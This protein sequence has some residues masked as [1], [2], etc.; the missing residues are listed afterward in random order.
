MKFS[1]T[2]INILKNFSSINQ[3]ILFKPGNIL[4]TKNTPNNVIAKAVLE[5]EMPQQF[6][7]YDLH[8]FLG[9]VSLFKEIDDVQVLNDHLM[10]KQGK[11]SIEY[12]FA[13]PGMIDAPQEKHIS[14]FSTVGGDDRPI[15]VSFNLPADVTTQLI[16]ALG[17]LQLTDVAV[18][19]DGNTVTVNVLDVKG[20]KQDVFSAE[21]GETDLEFVVIFK[22]ENLKLMN[23]EKNPISYNVGLYKNMKGGAIAGMF[24]TESG[25]LSY[26]IAADKTGSRL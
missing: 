18:I 9:A 21:V 10:L 6:A 7:I 24:T 17:V 5:D 1:K 19:G 13:D 20:K 15:A 25:N 8:Q 14:L 23:S 22:E 16:K 3:S 12:R 2:T 26:V 11:Q 4:Y